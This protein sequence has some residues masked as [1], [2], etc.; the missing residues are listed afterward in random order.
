[1]LVKAKK[2]NKLVNLLFDDAAYCPT[3]DNMLVSNNC[4]KRREII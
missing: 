2:D 3:L 4:L 1:M